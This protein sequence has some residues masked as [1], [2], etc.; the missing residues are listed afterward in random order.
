MRQVVTLA[1]IVATISGC[2]V[3]KEQYAAKESEAE[4]YKQHA[5][6]EAA[7]VTALEQENQALKGR[8]DT[9]EKQLADTTSKAQVTGAQKSRLEATTAQLIGKE[10]KLLNEQLL[11]A[12]NSS[13]LLPEVKRSLDSAAEA[14]AQ[15]TDKRVLVAAYTDDN[16]GGGKAGTAKRWQLS[17]ARALEVAKYLASRNYDPT[18]IAVAG[19]G[20]SRPVAPNDSIANRALN[21][22]AE[23]ILMPAEI[24]LKTVDVNPASLNK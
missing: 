6:G 23:L 7:K 18:L 5:S 15:L 9:I 16:E 8:L 4:K 21:R 13:K 2:G 24:N 14:V 19:F 20:E 10:S 17:T 22:R 1:L 3:S 12:E 11:F